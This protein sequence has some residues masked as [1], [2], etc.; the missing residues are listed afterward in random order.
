[1]FFLSRLPDN[2]ELYSWENELQHYDTNLC[3]LYILLFASRHS[4]I[5]LEIWYSRFVRQIDK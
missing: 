1:M 4:G 3:R 2:G 5:E